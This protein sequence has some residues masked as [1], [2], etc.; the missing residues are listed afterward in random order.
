MKNFSSLYINYFTIIFSIYYIIIYILFSI[1]LTN[2]IFIN[3]DLNQ[4]DSLPLSINQISSIK[5]YIV[6]Y[7]AIE[8]IYDL[9]NVSEITSKDIEKLTKENKRELHPAYKNYFSIAEFIKN[10]YPGGDVV[11]SSR[12][13]SLF[14]STSGIFAYSAKPK[15]IVSPL[16]MVGSSKYGE[17]K[18]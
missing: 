10:K 18:L 1:V 17:Y 3:E 16:P 8:S 15:C 2:E 7:G 6:E 9:L 5:S 12:K 14:P 11:V 4:I 13:P